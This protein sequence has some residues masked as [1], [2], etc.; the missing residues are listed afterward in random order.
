[1]NFRGV[2]NAGSMW[3]LHFQPNR[4]QGVQLDQFHS[5]TTLLHGIGQ[6]IGG[7]GVTGRA[8]LGLFLLLV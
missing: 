6:L 4:F 1:M 5:Q 8:C 3:V 2:T 7:G